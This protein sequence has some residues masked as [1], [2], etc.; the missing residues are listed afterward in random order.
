MAADGSLKFDTKIN[1]DGFKNGVSSI[2]RAGKACSTAIESTGRSVENAFNKSTSISTLESQITQTKSQIAALTAELNR[3]GNE[4]IP[5]EEFKWYSDSIDKAEKKLENLIYRQEKMDAM[6]TS[7][8]SSSWKSLQYDIEQTNRMLETYRNELE[9]LSEKEK[10]TSGKDTTQYQQKAA[11][12]EALTSKLSEQQVKLEGLKTKEAETA[13]ESEKLKLIGENAKVSNPKIVEL[14]R[15]LENLNARQNEL[16]SAGV[17]QG[18]EEFDRN[19]QKIAY[20]NSKLGEYKNHLSGSTEKSSRFG[21]SAKIAMSIAKKAVSGL[22]SSVKALGSSLA[23]A[24]GNG[25]QSLSSKLKGLHKSAGSASNG[26]FKLSNMFKLML[27][28]MAMRGVIQGVR[29]G[30]QNLSQYSSE[31]QASI[32]SLMNSMGYLKNSFAAAFAP[33]LSAIVP[34]LNALINVIATALNYVNQFFSAL[35]G[36]TTF[37]KA[38]KAN[39]GYSK[40][41]GGT[42]GAAKKTGKEIKKIVAPFDELVQLQKESS[43]DSNSGG[44]G[45]GG[46]ATPQGLFETATIDKGIGDFANKL[47]E[48]F[49]AGDWKGLGE[50]LGETINSAIEDFTKF[51]SWDNLGAKITE[52]VTA[53]TT[54]FNSLVA[55]IDWYALGNM[56]ATGINTIAMTLFLLLTQ[57]DWL[58]LGAAFATGLNG[59]IQNV[60]WDLIGI[61]IGAYFQAQIAM[62]FGFIEGFDWASLGVALG[63][64]LNGFISQIDWIMLATAIGDG[65]N[66]VLNTLFSFI[67]TFNW[68]ELSQSL[69]SG[70]NLVIDTIE[71]SK[72][73]TLLAEG[74]ST[75]FNFIKDFALTFD[76]TGFGTS[77]GESINSFAE[78]FDW[79]SFSAISTLIIGLLDSLIAFIAEVD[80]FKLGDSVTTALV[81]IDWAGM[82]SKLFEVIGIALGSFAVFIG[83]LLA[84]GVKASVDFFKGETEACGGNVVLG[85]YNGIKHIIAGVFTWLYTNM[86]KPFL[87]ALGKAF[88]L[89]NLGPTLDNIAKWLW[90]G[91]CIGIK[92]M[93]FNPI[94][95]IKENIT[96][97]FING[98]KGLLG[99]HSPS[100]VMSEMGGYT[101]DGFSEGVKNKKSSAQTVITDWASGVVSWFSN[102]LGISGGNSSESEKWANST[103]DGFNKSVTAKQKNSQGIME[104]W[105]GNIRNWFIG[106]GEG[107]G[108]N[109]ASWT[110]FSGDIIKAFGNKITSSYQDNKSSIE[111]WA[112]DTRK[113]FIGEGN[114][115]GVNEIS[116]TKFAE[117]ILNAFKNKIN[118]SNQEVKSSMETWANG[119]RSW[120]WGDTNTTGETGLYKS[121]YDMAKRINEG[122]AKGI[123]TFAHLA[124]NAIRTWASELTAAAKSELDIHSPSRVFMKIAGFVV[125]GFNEG[126]QDK[127]D[128]SKTVL[129]GWLDSIQHWSEKTGLSVPIEFNI[130]NARNYFPDVALGKVIPPRAGEINSFKSSYNETDST[131][132]ILNRLNDVIDRLDVDRPIQLVLNCKGSMSSLVRELKPELDKE[133]TRQGI[134]LVVV[135]GA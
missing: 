69:A 76:W 12:L 66:G 72:L 114:S 4:K 65:I 64:A 44:G 19:A 102:K 93:F 56:F 70:L 10:H 58:Q 90:E 116:W 24:A 135:G 99:I 71:W 3:L 132:N 103:M 23:K 22:V 78:N 100:T 25:I 123:N 51:I 75:A 16:R 11:A 55:T 67:T 110:K 36:S 89:Q 27:I 104:S 98:I 117:N 94:G 86:V 6:G 124:K 53:F 88:G 97:P 106:S 83:G 125:D 92:R 59:L 63:T 46:P 85:I 121:F 48:L 107:K 9:W 131:E 133:S 108:I 126:L 81:S 128:T 79:T 62:L 21:N 17:G 26:I 119:V 105:A 82:A 109:T 96:D 87:L 8:R 113:W 13:Q 1:T 37:I 129:Q 112:D 32:S 84:Q 111:K 73:G 2:K 18:Y 74:L 5:T 77:L 14:S 38:K 45:G 15:V 127:I 43:K 130:P 35:G 115:K 91:F 120:F 101:V 31:T 134:S 39:D 118:T 47:K 42:G 61:T 20:I 68:T 34:A 41:L 52:I 29:E 122:F 28:R 49:K 50:F 40:S 33:I 30:L 60:D 54:L 57:I 95:F 80:W 7:N